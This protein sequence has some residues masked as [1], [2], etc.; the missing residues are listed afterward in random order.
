MIPDLN[1]VTRVCSFPSE[2]KNELLMMNN[3]QPV[4]KDILI[5]VH[6]QLPYLKNCVESIR[7]NTDNYKLYIWDNASGEEMKDWLAEQKDIEIHG[8]KVNQGFI[9]PNNKL[10]WYSRSPYLVLLNS[11]TKVYPGWDRAMIAFLQAGYAQAGYLGGFLD[12][13]GFGHKFGFGENVD[14]LCGWCFAMPR[15]IFQQHGLFDAHHLTF[16][17]CEDADLSLRLREA[18]L[19]L[20]ALHLGLVSHYQNKTIEEVSKVLDCSKAIEAN[21]LYMRKRW[22]KHLPKNPADAP[23]SVADNELLVYNASKHEVE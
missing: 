14:Y 9:L 18:N 7:E 6:N 12:W 5:V 22:E 13:R 11:D 3:Y 1:P 8:S 23:K 4:D 21:H 16:A 10:A 15:E 19:R 17:Y 2:I 20:Y